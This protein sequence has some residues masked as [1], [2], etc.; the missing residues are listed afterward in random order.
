MLV[1]DTTVGLSRGI[2]LNDIMRGRVRD[3]VT[4]SFVTNYYHFDGVQSDLLLD[5][6][7]HNAASET[8]LWGF[9]SV[10]GNLLYRNVVFPTSATPAIGSWAHGSFIINPLPASAGYQGATCTVA[11]SPS[12]WKTYGLIS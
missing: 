6:S 5:N 2:Y 9:G 4:I 7:D 11:G 12:T 1:S 10:T 3:N 8:L